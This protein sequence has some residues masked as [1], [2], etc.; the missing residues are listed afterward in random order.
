MANFV[1]AHHYR[2]QPFQACVGEH[3][4][5]GTPGCA[6]EDSEWMSG[7]AQST[8][9]VDHTGEGMDVCGRN[10]QMTIKALQVLSRSRAAEEMGQ[11]RWRRAEVPGGHYILG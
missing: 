3:E 2:K 6:G 1:A 5:G 7:P 9:Q 4:C 11:Y 8:E 10:I